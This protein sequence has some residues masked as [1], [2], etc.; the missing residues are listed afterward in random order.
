VPAHTSPPDPQP[1]EQRAGDLSVGYIAA[2]TEYPRARK[3]KK[4]FPIGFRA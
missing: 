1:Y 3:V 2:L 4:K